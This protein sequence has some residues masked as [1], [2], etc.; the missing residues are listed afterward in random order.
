M[1]ADRQILAAAVRNLLHNAFTFTRPR[2]AVT[3]QAA[4]SA[5]RVLIEIEDIE[6]EGGGLAGGGPDDLFRQPEQR[7]ADRTGLG[8][9]FSRWGVEANHGR[10]H[11]RSL[12]ERGC[13]F[14]VDLPRLPV[15]DLVIS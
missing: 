3:L 11:A 10:I 2:T 14:T 6:D 4:A 15:P 7:R 9:A 13:I 1:E 12:P 5:E 8:L